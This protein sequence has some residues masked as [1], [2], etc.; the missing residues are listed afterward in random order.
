M[1]WK[2]FLF[3]KITKLAYL[4]AVCFDSCNTLVEFDKENL[5]ESLEE[6]DD[7]DKY[8]AFFLFPFNLFDPID[9]FDEE[10]LLDSLE[11]I[12]DEDERFE[13]VEG[14]VM[15]VCEL[16]SKSCGYFSYSDKLPAGLTLFLSKCS[17]EFEPEQLSD[18]SDEL[19]E[20][21]EPFEESLPSLFLSAL[22]AAFVLSSTS[23]LSVALSLSLLCEACSLLAPEL[24]FSTATL[25]LA[26]SLWCEAFSLLLVPELSFSTVTSELEEL[27]ESSDELDEEDE[28]FE[29]ALPSLLLSA[30]SV[31]FALSSLSASS[32]ALS[33][34]LSCEAFLLLAP[35]FSFSTAIMLMLSTSSSTS[36]ALTASSTLL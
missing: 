36:F 18:A 32:V 15:F 12:D 21:D 23:A 35:K 19:G 7:A 28:P 34:F 33:L 20:E 25:S 17:D 3:G 6:L 31:A 14:C 11:E 2:F 8:F 1:W 5:S 22:S 13:A 30:S 26:L 24:S 27:S 9:E 4:Y 29:V 10:E 16:I